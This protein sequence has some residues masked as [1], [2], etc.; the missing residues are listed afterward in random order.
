MKNVLK[1]IIFVIYTISVF[2]IN[3]IR[4]LGILFMIGVPAVTESINDS[5]K[6]R[7]DLLGL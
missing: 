5:R 6:E 1:T 2:F 7:M 3:N 4:I